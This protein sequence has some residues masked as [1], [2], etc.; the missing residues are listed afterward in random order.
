M[1]PAPS[2]PKFQRPTLV[3]LSATAMAVCLFPAADATANERRF[4]YAYETNVLPQGAKEVEVWTTWRNGR[5]NRYSRFDHR[6]EF[7]WG[8]SD[9]LQTAIYL[10]FGGLSYDSIVADQKQRT[11][12]FDYQGVSSEWK[13]KL[14]DRSAD[15]IG[16]ALYGE[17]TMGPVE[18]EFEAKFLF[19]K[20]IGKI[21]LVANL[22]GELALENELEASGETEIEKEFIGEVDVAATYFLSPKLSLGLELRS[23]N[24]VG[25]G[26]WEAGAV[27][28]GP[29]LAYAAESWWIALTVMPQL[30][31]L[32]RADSY[33][34]KDR[35]DLGAHEKLNARLL[36]SFHL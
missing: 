21:L 20:Q 29:V 32:K 36:L 22:V 30:P 19:D 18:T 25:H 2:S 11:S 24:I 15:P 6:L 10:N 7:E 13:Y 27:Y 31:A 33:T 35:R 1:R 14:S 23:H 9:R 26:E 17:V 34:G 12:S 3:A 5:E 16:F 8:L 28:L 4:T